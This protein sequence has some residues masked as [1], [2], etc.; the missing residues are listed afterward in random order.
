[1]R[2]FKEQFIKIIWIYLNS[3]RFGTLTERIGP[4]HVGTLRRDVCACT[5]VCVCV[6]LSLLPQYDHSGGIPSVMTCLTVWHIDWAY[7][8]QTWRDVCVCA[9]VCARVCLSPSF[10]NMT[11]TVMVFRQW[12]HDNTLYCTAAGIKHKIKLDIVLF[13]LTFM[14]AVSVSL[15]VRS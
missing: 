8:A 14:Y 13:T 3:W 2:M 12:W 7:W 9:R 6:S 4:R 5:C 11:R 1:M 15:T 10:H